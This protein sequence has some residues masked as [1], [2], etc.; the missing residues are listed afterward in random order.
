MGNGREPRWAFNNELML[1]RH[2]CIVRLRDK[3]GEKNKA[4]KLGTW[5]LTSYKALRTAYAEAEQTCLLMDSSSLS[6]GMTLNVCARPSNQGV[7][8][9]STASSYSVIPNGH[10]KQEIWGDL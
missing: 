3:T 7:G 4:P 8:E 2:I 9:C 5:H 10:P 1:P 6:S